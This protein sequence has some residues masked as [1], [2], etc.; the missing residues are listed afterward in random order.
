M[1]PPA[2][3][4]ILAPVTLHGL[5]EPF[6]V[7]LVS[8]GGQAVEAQRFTAPE[9][10]RVL[11]LYDLGQVESA[12]PL[13]RGTPDAPKA[14]IV[15][16]GRKYLLKRRA[17]GNDDPLQVAA[18]HSVVLHV[19]ERGFPTPALIGT[20]EDNNSMLQ[21]GR[22]VYELFEFVEGQP[23]D[24]TPDQ[25]RQAGMSLA[26]LHGML[27]TCHP[28]FEVPVSSF[29][30]SPTIAAR[31]ERLA[32]RLGPDD[33]RLATQVLA[34]YRSA[35]GDVDR[36]GFAGLSRQLIHADW[37][38]G[39]LLFLDGRLNGVLDFDSPRLAPRVIDLASGALQFSLAA[40]RE[41][42]LDLDGTRLNAFL[43]GYAQTPGGG[44]VAAERSMLA[45]LMVES[46][47]AEAAVPLDVT[48]RFG[49]WEA[50]AFL[51][52]VLR[53]IPTILAPGGTPR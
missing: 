46:L 16:R 10:A 22:Q 17:P 40:S 1:P 33:R 42:T 26:E 29:H 12:R 35:A 52:Q 18:G 50:R 51:E 32:S 21:I 27:V 3:S 9:L 4:S 6:G 47:I 28:Q 14:V 53:L 15:A 36:G 39:N 44:I 31:L 7:G 38:P 13:L 45:P 37:H 19:L 24:T 25:C 11:S 8:A 30:D 23:C 2:G 34:K 41:G 48:G 5:R 43:E 20:R 49:P